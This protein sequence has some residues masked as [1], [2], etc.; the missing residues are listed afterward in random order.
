[1]LFSMCFIDVEGV[2]TEPHNSWM[3][4][5]FEIVQSITR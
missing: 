3:R 5:V 4:Q 2:W 1:M